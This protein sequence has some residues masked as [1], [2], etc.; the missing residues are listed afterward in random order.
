[1]E[2]QTQLSPFCP[3]LRQT[4]FK[5]DLF[6]IFFVPLSFLLR[7]SF[8]FMFSNLWVLWLRKKSLSYSPSYLFLTSLCYP[9]CTLIGSA[10]VNVMSISAHLEVCYL[11]KTQHKLIKLR[12]SGSKLVNIEFFI[13]KFVTL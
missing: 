6:S 3:F 8:P 7:L 12:V 1:M 11:T 10:C 5:K 2:L 9:S 13:T 4:F